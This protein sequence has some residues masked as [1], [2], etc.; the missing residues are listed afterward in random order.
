MS[1]GN[2]RRCHSTYIPSRVHA[3]W[4]TGRNSHGT[5]KYTALRKQRCVSS[6]LGLDWQV[7]GV[8]EYRRH[9]MTDPASSHTHLLLPAPPGCSTPIPFL[10]WLGQNRCKICLGKKTV[11]L[12][13]LEREVMSILVKNINLWVR[14]KNTLTIG[15]LNRWSASLSLFPHM[16]SST[17][18]STCLTVSL[19]PEFMHVKRWEHCSGCSIE[20]MLATSIAVLQV[21]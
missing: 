1:R 3:H 2:G 5:L 12:I 7:A 11:K 17:D 15:H 6:W 8:R 13:W 14:K 18:D 10:K 21:H 9:R 4:F 16:H 19:N 20:E